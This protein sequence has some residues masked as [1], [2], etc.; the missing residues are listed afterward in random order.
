MIRI[1]NLVKQYGDQTALDHLS[2]KVDK[3]T[4]LGLLGPN[5]AGK[6]TLVAVLNGLTD[7]QEGAVEIFGL[8]LKKN[9]AE[10]RRRSAFIPQS[11]AL[12]ETLTVQENLHFFAGLQHIDRRRLLRN[13]DYAVEVNQL[14]PLLNRKAADLSGG[15]QQR[16]NIAIGLLNDPELLYFDEPTA[17]IDV[18]LRSGILHSISTLAAE[19]KTVVYTSHYLPEIEKICDTA[20]IIHRGKI[21]RQ[22]TLAQL[23][24]EGNSGEA[25]VELAEKVP[26]HLIA[27]LGDGFELMADSTTLKVREATAA[28]T[29]ALLAALEQAHIAVKTIRY[30]TAGLEALYLH[31]TA[32]GRTDV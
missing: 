12:Y 6:S 29:A 4:V 14:Q 9:I 3:G 2:L 13:L 10:I 16:L 30:D 19:G 18:E 20:A 31:I 11:L 24:G 27:N 22:G 21:I 8:E 1:Q 7:F 25:L 15:Q 28:N 32:E 26:K 5:G 17:G 23:L